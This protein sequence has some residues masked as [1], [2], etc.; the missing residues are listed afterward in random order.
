LY[1]E[2]IALALGLP[3]RLYDFLE[4]EAKCELYFTFCRT[5]NSKPFATLPAM[6][7]SS[8][9]ASPHQTCLTEIFVGKM[10]DLLQECLKRWTVAI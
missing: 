3:V 2:W 9:Q 6:K 1:A 4:P 8:D 10:L 5:T 7:P